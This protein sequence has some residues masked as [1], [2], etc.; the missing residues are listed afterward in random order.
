MSLAPPIKA[1]TGAFS[2]IAVLWMILAG[3]FSFSAFVVLSAYAPDL[4]GGSDGGAHALSRSAVGYAGLVGLLRDDDHAVVISRLEPEKRGPWSLLVVTPPPGVPGPD[5]QHFT[6]NGPT[7]VVLPKWQVAPDPTHTGWV[8][9]TGLLDL[10]ELQK[11]LA[12]AYLP[13]QIVRRS[14]RAAPRLSPP[15]GAAL[16]QP[17]GVIDR[18]QTVTYGAGFQPLLVN[19]DGQAVAVTTLDHRVTILADPDLLNTQG[20]KDARTAAMAVRLIDHLR[21]GDGPVAFD[22]NLD[23]FNSPPSLLKLALQPPFLGATLLLL[24]AGVLIGLHAAARFGAPVASDRVLAFGKR[25]LV[26]NSAALIRLAKREPRMAPRYLALTR[27]AVAKALG[28]T[29]LGEADL[30]PVLDRAAKAAGLQ[31]GLSDFAAEVATVKTR[32]DLIRVARD[33]YHWRLEMTRERR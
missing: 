20:L 6:V 22:V 29:R 26:D 18:L 17:L 33:L 24:A 2:P 9:Q 30:D 12:K 21:A 1:D 11:A 15:G 27:A 5:L 14:D 7:L 10:T 4:R 13:V 23:G 32:A 3:V 31:R 19:A 28:V 8:I 25:A 16:A